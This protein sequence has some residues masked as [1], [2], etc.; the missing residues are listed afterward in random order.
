M[1]QPMAAKVMGMYV[2]R[3]SADLLCPLSPVQK[4]MQYPLL[5]VPRAS[6][7]QGTAWV[8]SDA[9]VMLQLCSLRPGG[10]ISCEGESRG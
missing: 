4:A 10:L 7:S 2:S 5:N 3:A 9:V 6:E 1:N 8:R